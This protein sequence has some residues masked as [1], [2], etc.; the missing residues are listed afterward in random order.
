MNLEYDECG[1]EDEFR[2][3]LVGGM[4]GNGMERFHFYMCLVEKWWSGAAPAWEYILKMRNET[5]R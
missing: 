2:V 4:R 5:A 3:C 1:V